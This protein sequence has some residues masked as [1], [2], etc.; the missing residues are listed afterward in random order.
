MKNIPKKYIIVGIVVVVLLLTWLF[1]EDIK[2]LFHKSETL[3]TSNP[4]PMNGSANTLEINSGDSIVSSA[5]GKNVYSGD[6]SKVLKVAKKNEFIGTVT[7]VT[8]S[9]YKAM[10]PSGIKIY[11]SKVN[12]KKF[13]V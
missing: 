12:V 5:E 3:T 10:S 2:G 4:E 7:S 1:W 8:D 9:G 6:M 13:K 11:V